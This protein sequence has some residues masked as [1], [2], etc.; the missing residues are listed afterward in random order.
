MNF[1]ASC[2]SVHHTG[3]FQ[4]AKSQDNRLAAFTIYPSTLCPFALFRSRRLSILPA[5][6]FQH[7]HRKLALPWSDTYTVYQDQVHTV[8]FQDVPGMQC[9]R[10]VLVASWL[11]LR[12]TWTEI[13]SAVSF[14]CCGKFYKS[15]TSLNGPD[16]FIPV[17]GRL[18]AVLL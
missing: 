2:T 1:S 10:S 18:R 16:E 17:G 3:A 13:R 4:L 8:Q 5:D 14:R 12:Q 15:T 9:R 11:A 7:K 6:T